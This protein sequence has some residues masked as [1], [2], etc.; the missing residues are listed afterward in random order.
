MASRE[1]MSREAGIAAVVAAFIERCAA[2][3]TVEVRGRD[4]AGLRLDLPGPEARTTANDPCRRAIREA[5]EAAGGKR[6]TAASLVE[7]IH[8]KHG[9]DSWARRTIIDRIV[10]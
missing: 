1:P 2:G 8:A 4:G 6:L 9:E 10:A 5:L 7:A 3:C